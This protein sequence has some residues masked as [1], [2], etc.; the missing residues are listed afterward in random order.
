MFTV[1]VGHVFGSKYVQIRVICLL[2]H[3]INI[4]TVKVDSYSDLLHNG[5]VNTYIFFF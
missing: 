4:N 1:F 2:Q 3:S 5:I